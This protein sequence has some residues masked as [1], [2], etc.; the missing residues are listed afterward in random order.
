MTKLI[1]S[2]QDMSFEFKELERLLKPENQKLR[3]LVFYSDRDIYYRYYEGFIDYIVAN[4]DFDICYVSSHRED[5][6][7]QTTSSRI[8]PFYLKHLLPT[9]FARL[10]SKVL[11]LTAT[12]LGQGANIKRT[13]SPVSHVYVFHAISSTHCN[14]NLGAF[15]NYDSVLCVAKYQIDELR[16]TESVYG[17]K[18]KE[19]IE[20]GYPL[21]EG[22]Y[23]D[24][25]ERYS[26][27][28]QSERKLCLVAPTW[29]TSSIME[30]CIEQL[31]DAFSQSE[32]QVLLRPH[33]EFAKRHRKRMGVI[34]EL[35][36]KTSNVQLQTK[37]STLDCLFQADV[38]ITDHSSIAFEY[39]LSTKR[40]VLFV[41]TKPRIDNPQWQKI[42]IEPVE[43]RY[44]ERLGQSVSPDRLEEAP[45][46]CQQLIQ[47]RARFQ[48]DLEELRPELVANW[49]KSAQIGGDHILRLCKG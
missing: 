24:F 4:S 40:P 47:D 2:I 14:Y 30:T 16:K 42:G 6:I 9:A 18:P 48:A 12:D 45:Q 49:Q 21:L 8:K 46:M 43:A 19:L 28:D 35:A 26:N 25:S 5:P 17:L 36:N 29:G 15:D 44:R 13:P 39:A 11:V 32:F 1:D 22:L 37:L 10:D 34:Q 20:C 31:I 38:L 23:R 27:Q 33:P 3:R 41:D 7:F